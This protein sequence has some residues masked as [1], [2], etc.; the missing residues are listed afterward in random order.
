MKLSLSGSQKVGRISRQAKEITMI[1]INKDD[2]NYYF[3]NITFLR[4]RC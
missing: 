1:T 4:N 3:E 2:S